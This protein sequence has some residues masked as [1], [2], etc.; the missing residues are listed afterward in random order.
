MK[1][2]T[3]TLF[4]L[5]LALPFAG[6]A[7]PAHAGPT[8][9]ASL[10]LMS[11]DGSGTVKPNLMMIYDDSGSMAY[12]HTPDYVDDTTTCRGS[13]TI[14]QATVACV[15]GH[16][17]YH[18]PQFNRQYYNPAT[19]YLPPVKADQTT[20]DSQDAT[21]TSQWTNVDT[22]AY[23]LDTKDLTGKPT[24]KTNL[25][26]GFPDLEW[27]L[28]G[29][30][31]DCKRNIAGYTY[32][33]TLYTKS[34]A[35]SGNPYYYTLNVNEYCK[36]ATLKDCVSTAVNAT[37]PNTT[38]KTAAPLRWC[39]D[40]DLTKCQ[41]KYVTLRKGKTDEVA[42]K[43]PRFGDP[44]R[45]PNWY[46]TITINDSGSDNKVMIER[47]VAAGVNGEQI[48]TNGSISYTGG[49]NDTTERNGLAAA[50]ANSILAKSG[51]D[52]QFTACLRTANAPVKACTD[53]GITLE[54]DNIVA[55]IAI[56][57]PRKNSKDNCTVVKDGVRVSDTLYVTSPGATGLIRFTGTAG[58][59]TRITKLV[60][61][62][63]TFFTQALSLSRNASAVTAVANI[64]AS[65]GTGGSI[66]AYV[67]GSSVSPQCLLEQ[68]TTL[69]LVA[70]AGQAGSTP[71][72]GELASKNT[73]GFTV[74]SSVNA[75]V[76]TSVSGFD[77]G[78][79]TRTDIVRSRGTYPKAAGRTDCKVAESSCSYEEEMTNFA[80]WYAYYKSRNQMMKTAV[81]LAMKQLNKDYKVGLVG[82]QKAAVDKTYMAA[83]AKLLYPKPFTGDQ[84]IT[85]YNMLYAMKPNG[86][87]PVRK[88]LH[89][90]GNMYA[91]KGEYRQDDPKNPVD[92]VVEFAC[93]QNFTFVTT[94][95]YWNGPSV[96]DVVSNDNTAD[97]KR[98]CTEEDG[99]VDP[100][101][102][103]KPSLADV[104]LYW[105][106]GGSNTDPKDPKQKSLRPDLEV[107]EPQVPDN[108]S[109]RRL[110]MRTYALGLGVDG[111][112][113]YEP[114]Y[115]VERK[116]GGDLDNIINKVQTGCP[117][118][119]DE[120]YRWPDPIVGDVNLS[121]THQ[122]RVDDLWHAAING[123]GKY[124]AAADT[125]QVVD[126]LSEAL[127]AIRESTGAAAAAATST[128]NLSQ[129]DKDIFS[130]TFT[131]VKWTGNLT[132]REINL[133][134]GEVDP[135]VHWSSS[136]TLGD[137]VAA[138]S[139]TRSIWYRDASGARRE[140]LASA[141]GSTE[142]AW[143]TNKCDA[144]SQCG[145][146]AP[147]NRTIV[148]QPAT[149]V[150]WLRGQQQYANDAILR[151][152]HL[153]EDEETNPKGTA[154]P[155]VLGD[156]ASSKP[157]Y[158]R[159]ARKSYAD[160]GY[161]TYRTEQ[162]ERKPT[163]F[164]ASNDGMLHAFD[165]ASGAEMWAY[166][167]RITMK[168][169]HL[170]ASLSYAT[171]HQFTVDGSPEL[172]DVQIGGKWRTILVGGLNA[173]GRGYYALDVTDPDEPTP[174]WEICADSSV[175]SGALYQPQMGFSFGN[176]QF[177]TIKDGTDANGN[178]K[179]RWVVFM[180]SGY[181]N[182]PGADGLSVGSGKGYLFVVD[183]ATGEQ[184]L[185]LG[186][187][188]ANDPASGLLTTGSGG[189]GSDADGVE[190]PSGFAKITA[191]T[192]NPNT[193]PLVTYVYGGDNLG[194]MWRFDF[195]GASV[196][197]IRMG[198]AG[199][200]QPITS[201]PD[202]AMCQ[203]DTTGQ[204]ADALPTKRVVVF[205]TG[206][207]L[208]YDDIGTK[209]TQ[210]VYILAD[211]GVAI[212]DTSWRKEGFAGRTFTETVKYD[213]T[214]PSVP[215]SNKFKIEG[216]K[217]DLA[218]Q[219]G[220]YVDFD[221]NKGER[222][223]LDPKIVGG[224]LSVVTNVPESS[225]ACAV[226]GVSY[227]YHLNVCNG[228]AVASDIAGSILSNSAAAVGF[229]IVRLPSGALK[230]ITT[231][232]T[233]QTITSEVN[234][235]EAEDARRTGWRRVRD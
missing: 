21:K 202:V 73:L 93:Q 104:A 172:A 44:Y 232:A 81:G 206:R 102:Q 37:A 100:S 214:K 92:K 97:P 1:F 7:L 43:Y 185:N 82:L 9:L 147:A 63:Q 65:I 205:G 197:R 19:R 179:S 187:A 125:Q 133:V 2:K 168:K 3:N 198:N 126:G 233:G 24:N 221:N 35:F 52:R 192:A 87:T 216:T 110:H 212:D 227:G 68:N 27:C 155:V 176:P 89:E 57:C 17:P 211:N 128:P 60:F 106:N 96:N 58:T 109:N 136:W 59:N 137:K 64:V 234:S 119:D 191:I 217:V 203:V 124:F 91:N 164:I 160:A 200:D 122:S 129:E 98:Y 111:V 204:G 219:D 88:A 173:G 15:A 38:Y 220:W 103:S 169:L 171:E 153:S 145:N 12:Q 5:L 178:A 148:N 99:C 190:D 131:T 80:N 30:T 181:N 95:G 53:Y 120:V 146:L 75:F 134:S 67:G 188:G 90:I 13:S 79:F 42:Y 224:T 83:D 199:P 115:N 112:M 193:D 69:C 138:T 117:W 41:A 209:K 140:F 25:V 4:A 167:P 18:T 222:V 161:Q 223:N 218:K 121:D 105:Y 77:T 165:A 123:G 39:S 29:S 78:V 130:S 170:Q 235:A 56:D 207:L 101:S 142:L 139:D 86:G 154:K 26:T 208:D 127:N 162:A 14:K 16:V 194:Q 71:S 10:P 55:V 156:I 215:R 213:P 158:M 22:D 135:T 231:T 144:L 152:Y 226:G 114:K 51:L 85:W 54:A 182:I 40:T 186:A 149:L 50:L 72:I 33:N 118:T 76:P 94:D 31:T 6:A 46:S 28:P 184:V 229:I 8:G 189:I 166:M 174:L 20:Y 141:M 36:D 34:Q 108:P 47:V 196:Q 175:C 70:P 230:M 84:R 157:A 183:A 151:G 66:K 210:S 150:N 225:T 180:T 107:D 62:G 48:I 195:T 113:T 228:K 201:R 61:G 32:P 132:K 116:A 49:T 74:V 143:F 159:G 11:L 177:G 163:V 45:S 23:G